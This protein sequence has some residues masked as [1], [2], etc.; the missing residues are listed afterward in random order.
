MFQMLCQAQGFN[1]EEDNIISSNLVR[2]IYF[3]IG[4]TIYFNFYKLIRYY[5]IDNLVIDKL[6]TSHPF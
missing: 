2:G 4:E 5:F 3:S 1:G 6:F